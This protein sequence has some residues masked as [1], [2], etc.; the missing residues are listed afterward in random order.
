MNAPMEPV[1]MRWADCGHVQKG[2]WS[3]AWA[4]LI[5]VH[6]PKLSEDSLA[7][8]MAGQSQEGAELTLAVADGVGGGARGE[9]ASRALATHSTSVPRDSIG[10]GGAIAEWMGQADAEVQRQLRKVSYAPGA[11]TLAAAW[12]KPDGRGHLM[13][14][15]DARVCLYDAVGAE[16]AQRLCALL[17]ATTDQTYAHMLETPPQ[18]ACMDDPARMVGTGYMGEPELIEVHVASGQTLLLCSD[19]LH[20][21]LSPDQMGRILGQAKDLSTA[22]YQLAR[23]AC[24]RGSTDDI[25][26]LL[27][28]RI[29]PCKNQREVGF[30]AG[31]HRLT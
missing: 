13:R 16:T 29:A 20:R 5:G 2:G 11:A 25:S 4:Q 22:V 31:L 24:L 15:G 14:V 26:V 6:H 27:A 19:G 28:Q 3:V 21:S 12:L 23:D 7:Y 8:R 30:S 17:S 10:D 18:G 9:V 1:L